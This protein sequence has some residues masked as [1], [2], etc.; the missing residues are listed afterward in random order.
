MADNL[1]A[2]QRTA[3][4]RA[5]RSQNTTPEMRVRQTA[6]SLGYRY[7]LHRKDL[8][9]KPDLVFVS[10]RKIVFVHGCFWHMH[11][12]S[13]GRIAPVR[14][15]DYW[16]AKRERNTKRDKVNLRELRAA[17]WKILVVWECWTRDNARLRKRLTDF[18]D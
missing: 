9:G 16:H 8:L 11:K 12:C 5:V 18:L 15:A 7:A 10:R 17:D 4:M 13:H 3:C 14:N 2:E 1:T 6:H